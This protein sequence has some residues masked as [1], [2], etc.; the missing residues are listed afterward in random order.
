MTEHDHDDDLPTTRV[1]RDAGDVLRFAL[2]GEATLTLRSLRTKR[3]YTFNIWQSEDRDGK[4]KDRW[5]V[6]VLADSD[7]YIYV[8]M[9]NQRREFTLTRASKF[10]EEAGSVRAF[11]FFWSHLQAGSIAP[12]LEVRHHNRCGRCGRELT[13]PE[14]IERGIG[15]DC[16]EKM[17]GGA[18]RQARLR[19]VV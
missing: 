13:V 15:P 7:K 17:G 8:G 11:R 4:P 19:L 12:D 18:V 6:K 3:W 5:F 9:I 10:S 16:W 14:S 2:A 1:M